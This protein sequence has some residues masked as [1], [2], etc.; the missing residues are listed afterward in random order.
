MA[1]SEAVQLFVERGRAVRPGFALTGDDAP[2]VAELCRRLDGL[3]LALELAAARLRHLP[4]RALNARL[5]A[6]RLPLL[7]GGPRDAPARQRTLGATIA[8]S[9]DLLTPAEQALF[10][11]LAVFASGCTPTAAAAVCA[12][13]GAQTAG[14]EGE[15]DAPPGPPGA[16]PAGDAALDGL[17]AL[18][19]QSLLRPEEA[20]QD[21]EPRFRMLETVREFAAERLEGSGE[22]RAVRARHA[23][24]HLAL[25]ERAAPALAGPEQGA[26]L[27]RLEQE[28]DDLPAGAGLV[29]GAGP[30]GRGPAPGRRAAAVLADPGTRGRGPELARPPARRRRGAAGCR[31][32]AGPGRRR[33][34]GPRAGRP[35]RRRAA[36]RAAL[37]L[38]RA[39]G[40]AAG[41]AAALAG[42]ADGLR[43][44]GRPGRARALYE[45]A[46]GRWRTLG[47][48]GREATTLYALGVTA[49]AAG[50]P[51]RARALLEASLALHR[52]AGDAAGA[53][54]AL[55]VLGCLALWEGDAAASRRA[56]EEALAV[57]R[58]L[59]DRL[60]EA[61]AA[62]WLGQLAL[63]RGA[64]A[65]ALPLLAASLRAAEA[66]GDRWLAALG[67]EEFAHLLRRRGRPAAALRLLG[68]AA[69]VWRETGAGPLPADRARREALE[70]G[71]RAALAAA[72]ADAWGA[73]VRLTLSEAVAF[74]L[75]ELGAAGPAPRRARRGAGPAGL[76]RR[77][78]EVAA[79]VAEGLTN[80][81]I[82]V[83]LAVSERT[84][85]FHVAHVLAKLGVVARVQVAAWVAREAPRR[86]YTDRRAPAR[87]SVPA[88]AL[89]R[90]RPRR[91]PAG[92]LA[93][94][95]G[96]PRRREPPS[97]GGTAPGGRSA[98]PRKRGQAHGAPVRLGAGEG[99][100]IRRRRRPWRRT[101]RWCG[102]GSRHG[103][104]TTSR[105]RRPA[106]PRPSAPGCGAPSP[107]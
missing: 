38:S 18:A 93:L 31:A 60:G 48:R 43:F 61:Y 5:A 53:A 14:C 66:L 59:G 8:W 72:A 45:G 33:R 55:Q 15:G 39:A 34:A 29:R 19:D 90:T 49:V 107:G 44:R 25:A 54:W 100:P 20:D 106:G 51:A 74:A 89:S 56:F 75:T 32:G 37:R 94:A 69:G 23:A 9:H 99:D 40:D 3:P 81:Q 50:E 78:G 2:A 68:A 65:A 58:A 88:S 4:P 96:P 7:T 62:G 64:A 95:P 16:A 98:G 28:H 86:R 80:R 97:R 6:R 12:P 77:E 22:A 11:R 57:R 36:Y 73:G 83:R 105:R 102:A 41:V 63:R 26:W 85:D 79:L 24:Y 91:V 30:A 87:K 47:D 10:R 82:A 71:L 17:A 46:L 101:R 92:T 84:V 21:D 35:R 13:A 70:R 52:R 42:L 76:T 104:R 27:D 103:M 1:R 67:L